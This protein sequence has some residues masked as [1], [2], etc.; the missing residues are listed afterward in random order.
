MGV[1]ICWTLLPRPALKAQNVHFPTLIAH[2]RLVYVTAY[3]H[4]GILGEEYVLL[5]A[6]ALR[7]GRKASCN[8]AAG[9]PSH[10]ILHATPR[11]T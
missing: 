3:E 1:K 6:A 8:E 5:N 4:I 11:P 9:E 7:Y 2:R 10:V